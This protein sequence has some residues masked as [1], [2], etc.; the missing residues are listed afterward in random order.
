M[1]LTTLYDRYYF[2][3]RS[4]TRKTFLCL[5]RYG[6]DVEVLTK[7]SKGVIPRG[8]AYRRLVMQMKGLC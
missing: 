2:N 4:K 3:I 7:A 8:P 6:N 1:D 5:S